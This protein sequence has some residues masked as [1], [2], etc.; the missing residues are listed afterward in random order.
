[1]FRVAQG[2]SFRI[3]GTS[4]FAHIGTAQNAKP[5]RVCRHKAVLDSIVDHLY[6]VSGAIG[7]TVQIT[8][9]GGAIERFAS[10]CSRRG[11]RA[12]RECRENRGQV[13]HDV[14]FPANHHAVATIKAP[15]TATSPHIYI[16]NFL[17][18][19]LLSATNI[20]EVVRVA[21]VNENVAV[22]EM[23]QEVGDTLI[24]SSRRHHQPYR[25]GPSELFCKIRQRIGSRCSLLNQLLHRFW[26]S[27]EDYTLVPSSQQT[28]HH[29][30]PHSP[31]AD[32]SELHNSPPPSSIARISYKSGLHIT[33]FMKRYSA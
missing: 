24:H 15:Y 21:A 16:M 10:R 1:M 26:R 4:R 7:A 33:P 20:I 28:P 11:G 19:E 6:K 8:Q 25:S 5:F 31:E 14:F 23:R 29:V 22:L 32:H 9:F 18:C 3:D 27:V 30:R 13:R 2:C 17:W 12:W